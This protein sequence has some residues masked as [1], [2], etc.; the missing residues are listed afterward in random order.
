[1]AVSKPAPPAI[2]IVATVP[3]SIAVF[4]APHVRAIGRERPVTIVA[5]S[6]SADVAALLG[7]AVSFTPIP[8]ARQIAPIR[9]LRALVALWT[10]FRRRRFRIVQSITP[11]AG[12]LAMIAARL[13]GVPVRVHWFTGQV[14]AT[15]TGTA[16]WLLKTMDR[17]LVAC[18]THV[19]ADSPSQRTFLIEEGVV[20]EGQVEVF[21]DGSL[22]GV[23]T[24][25][26]RPDAA[27]RARIRRTLGIPADAIVV[28]YL[29]RLNEEKGVPDLA[30][31]FA[32]QARAESH[33]H[34]LIVGPSEVEMRQSLEASLGDVARRTRFVDFTPEPEAY[35]AAADIF[36]LAS[37]REGFGSSVIEAAACGVPAIGT[38]IYGLSDAIDEGVSGL[39][40]EVG[41][42]DGLSEAIRTLASRS[43]LRADMGAAARAR[44]QRLFRQEVLTAAL[45]QFHR[46]ILEGR[47]S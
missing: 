1:M 25:R 42:V 30:R 37:R 28:L 18:A 6:C 9:D 21:G 44:V 15:R 10:L 3:Y 20:R 47:P 12:L 16:R 43:D 24:A 4:M 31:A 23:D 13:A 40:V 45:L 14:W 35:M 2:C 11:K 22:C 39:L 29:G 33:L 36:V 5:S 41:D 7:P 32:E 34:L 19:L 46:R 26:F 8:I 38:R 17:V 27:A